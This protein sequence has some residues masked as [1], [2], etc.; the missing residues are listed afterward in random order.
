MITLTKTP[1]ISKFRVLSRRVVWHKGSFA[2]YYVFS[3]ECLI[4]NRVM[5][6]HPPSRATSKG[7]TLGVGG[8]SNHLYA[9]SS[10]Q[11]QENSLDVVTCIWI[12]KQRKDTNKQ[13]GTKQAERM[14]KGSLVIAKFTWRITE[15]LF[16]RLKFQC[17]KP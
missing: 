7:A 8:G 15:R 10:R 9:M 2:T 1:K 16:D 12:E 11:D 3:R 13:K 6:A 4:W 5:G 14:N 17:A